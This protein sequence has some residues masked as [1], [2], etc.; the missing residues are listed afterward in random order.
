MPQIV[1]GSISVTYHLILRG[2]KTIRTSYFFAFAEGRNQIWAPSTAIEGAIHSSIASRRGK[3]VKIIF[4]YGRLTDL[5]TALAPKMRARLL[6]QKTF[7]L[8]S[9]GR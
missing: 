1:S 5:A 8:Q 7:P 4:L 9:A 6:L 3:K 2:R